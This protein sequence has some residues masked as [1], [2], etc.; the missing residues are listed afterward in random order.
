MDASNCSYVLGKVAEQLRLTS[1][2]VEQKV[3]VVDGKVKHF[4]VKMIE[5]TLESDNKR[6][7]RIINAMSVVKPTGTLNASNW[8]IEKRN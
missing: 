2:I 8:S 1:E 6:E 7:K 4:M 5:V 3:E